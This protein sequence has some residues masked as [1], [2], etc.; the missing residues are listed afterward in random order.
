MEGGVSGGRS[1]GGLE[2]RKERRALL[3]GG[4]EGWKVRRKRNRKTCVLY[5][6]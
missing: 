2:E 4:K 6:I 5:I 1:R 3:S